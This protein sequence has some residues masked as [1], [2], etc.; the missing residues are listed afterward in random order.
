MK[1]K[2]TAPISKNPDLHLSLKDKR[3]LIKGIEH[4]QQERKQ[5]LRFWLK[6]RHRVPNVAYIMIAK[7]IELIRDQDL[8]LSLLKTLVAVAE[9]RLAGKK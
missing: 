4:W 3:K 7:T 9:H 6:E 5:R 8:R 2:R 1:A